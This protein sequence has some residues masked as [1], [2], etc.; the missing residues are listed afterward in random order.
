MRRIS[1]CKTLLLCTLLLVSSI[2][3]AQES[4]FQ[5]IFLYKFIE[6][7]SWPDARKTIVVGVVGETAVQAEFE[8]MLK[9]RGNTNLTVRKIT[10]ADASSCDVVYIP[11]SQSPG[12]S[13]LL[14]KLTGKSILIVTEAADLA[15][16]GAG[17]SFLKDG[18]KLSFAINKLSL[19]ARSLKVSVTLLTLGK[20]I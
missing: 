19:D 9:S 1:N 4:K 8:K 14:E 2:T 18:S 7:V 17:I 12:F 11:E 10:S 3:N 15:K 6:N 16:K 5:A 20:E 13:A